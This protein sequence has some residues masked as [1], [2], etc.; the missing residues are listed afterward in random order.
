[1]PVSDIAVSSFARL[2]VQEG[3]AGRAVRRNGTAGNPGRC[4][5]PDPRETLSGDRLMRGRIAVMNTGS[6]PAR[7]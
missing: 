6:R 1:M 7:S 3:H 5:R 4:A 2:A